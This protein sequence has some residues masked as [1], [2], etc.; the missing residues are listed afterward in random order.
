MALAVVALV[1][2]PTAFGH[3]QRLKPYPAKK[4]VALMTAGHRLN[5]AVI[6]GQV[7][8]NDVTVTLPFECTNCRFEGP[9]TARN[10]IFKRRVDLAG[11]TF[12]KPVQMV[13][14]TFEGPVSFGS[15]IA[16]SRFEDE[17]KFAM[18]T[19]DDTADF[20]NVTFA[21]TTF[22]L[23]RFKGDAIFAVGGDFDAE[24]R[25][26]TSFVRTSFAATADFRDRVF[27][28]APDFTEATF[29]GRSD[30]SGSTDFKKGATFEGTAFGPDT[31]FLG[32]TLEHE[33]TF[34]NVT[35]TGTLDLSSSCIMGTLDVSNAVLGGFSLADA[36]YDSGKVT[37]ED[38]TAPSFSFDISSLKYLQ[39]GDASSTEADRKTA[40]ALLEASAK[41]KNDLGLANDAH[42]RLQS[43]K[44][45]DYWQPFHLLDLFFYN[46]IAGYLVRP[47]H[48]LFTLL[49]LA[50]L[51]ALVRAFMLVPEPRTAGDP[52]RIRPGWTN[53]G[54]AIG[55]KMAVVTGRTGRWVHTSVR[56]GF[57][58]FGHELL[59]TLKLIWPGS[60]ATAKGRR[61]E[62]F[63]YRI[64]FVCML[65]GFANSNPTLRQM[66][67][68]LL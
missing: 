11:S 61:A 26:T 62:A 5:H 33:V 19:F 63:A 6:Q 10:A 68:A 22:D 35:S 56:P 46:W 64:L 25:G 44:S 20:E 24:F 2:V 14:A 39:A 32:A 9:I 1:V 23:A 42:Y 7:D 53:R 47:D 13:G 40:L 65:I 29:L 66:L 18:A 30:F 45:N 51:V 50:I 38:V 48:P 41:A 21:D 52:S 17:A 16:A 34:D 28:Q 57:A 59:D 4:A 12:T 36:V 58:H 8:L 37:L 15:T 27:N 49:A 3:A 67:D 31:S 60:G 43:L 54:H 55:A